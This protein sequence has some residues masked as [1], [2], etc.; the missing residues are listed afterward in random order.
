MDNDDLPNSIQTAVIGGF[1]RDGQQELLRPFVERYFASL[2]DVWSARTNETAQSIVIG[3][4]PTLLAEQST[5]DVGGRAGSTRTAA[6]RRRCAVWSSRPATEWP[7]RCTRR[8]STPAADAIATARP[9]APN[10]GNSPR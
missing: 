9:V 10:R 3:L 7:G 1:A 2:T 6:R 5:V 8:P 4:F